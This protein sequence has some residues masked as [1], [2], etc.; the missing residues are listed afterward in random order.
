MQEWRYTQG[1]A[2][3]TV[4]L[5]MY[6]ALEDSLSEKQVKLIGFSEIVPKSDPASLLLE[7]ARLLVCRTAS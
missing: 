7:K 2:M 5:I 6:S 1:F 3:V 4:P